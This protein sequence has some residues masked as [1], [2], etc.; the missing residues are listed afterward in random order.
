MAIIFANNLRYHFFRRGSGQPLLLLHGFSGSSQSWIDFAND[1]S[2]QRE[3]VAIDLLGHGK[4]ENP[5]TPERYAINRAAEDIITITNQLGW[6][7]FGLLGYSMGG[8]LALYLSL[9]YPEKIK[10]LILESA[11]PGIASEVERGQRL[12]WDYTLADRIEQEGIRSFFD[13][14]ER[15]P[16]FASQTAVPEH[17]RK[18][19]REQR[20]LNNALGLSN[21]LRGMGTGSQPSLWALLPQLTIP[22]LLLSGELDEKFVQI[23]QKIA[24]SIPDAELVVVKNAGHN[25]HLE[26]PK[27]FAEVVS[28]FLRQ[29]FPANS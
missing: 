11:S 8:R 4:S 9:H 12:E 17:R 27:I 24:R 29:T 20:L 10:A 25:I 2:T 7:R 5:Q 26:K 18:K 15:L 13:Y 14:W 22:T 21:S 1:L 19:L 28:N 16:L 6:E 3:V 23:N